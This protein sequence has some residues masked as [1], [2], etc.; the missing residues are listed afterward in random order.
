MSIVQKKSITF[1]TALIQLYEIEPNEYKGDVMWRIDKFRELA[2]TGNAFII[3]TCSKTRP[4]LES[5][6]TSYPETI[7]LIQLDECFSTILYNTECSHISLPKQRHPTKDTFQNICLINRKIEYTHDAMQ[8]N[9]YSSTHFAWID[10]SI[11]YIFKDSKQTC[12]YLTY[13]NNST[14]DLS[15]GFHIPGCCPKL[16]K[17]EPNIIKHPIRRFC[18]GFFLSDMESLETCFQLHKLHFHKFIQD[19]NTLVWEVNF[20]AYLECNFEWK[21]LWYYANHDDSILANFVD[22]LKA[23]KL[24]LM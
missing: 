6:V 5:L 20:W 1:V 22:I 14:T 21:P 13:M 24:G 3:Y 15:K 2:D 9:P 7:Q 4:L 16:S 17:F 10:F 23:T 12:Q 11:S 19:Y 18:G 8:R